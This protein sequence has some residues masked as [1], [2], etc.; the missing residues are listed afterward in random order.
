[1]SEKFIL[2]PE[3]IFSKK[4]AEFEVSY[5]DESGIGGKTE[6]IEKYEYIEIPI[7]V[8]HLINNKIITNLNFGAYVAFLTSAIYEL[9][10]PGFPPYDTKDNTN[11]ID[12]GLFLGIDKAIDTTYGQLLID[13]R[14]GFGIVQ[15]PNSTKGEQTPIYN[16]VKEV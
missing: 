9:T 1:L 12:A 14:Y 3:L 8:K 15:V 13:F 10:L 5:T 7:I 11:K 4:G 2:Q 6:M 16:L